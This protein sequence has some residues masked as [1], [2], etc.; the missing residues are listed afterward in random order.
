MERIDE[1]LTTFPFFCEC[2]ND[3]TLY[4]SACAT[5]HTQIEKQLK[6]RAVKL[7][8]HRAGGRASC[9]EGGLLYHICLMLGMK[10][11][12]EGKMFEQEKYWEEIVLSCDT[13]T[14]AKQALKTL[15]KGERIPTRHDR[16]LQY[17]KSQSNVPDKMQ[18]DKQK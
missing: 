11:K 18:G 9:F 1:N 13:E 15:I 12:R 5:W 2:N 6:E 3:Q 17:L 7:L 4:S 16:H 14:E 10:E 8:L